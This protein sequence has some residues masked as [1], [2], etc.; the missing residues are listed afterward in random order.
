[1]LHESIWQR[2]ISISVFCNCR[3]FYPPGSTSWKAFSLFHNETYSIPVNILCCFFQMVGLSFWNKTPL[4]RS[5]LYVYVCVSCREWKYKTA[6]VITESGQKSEMIERGRGW[7]HG[8]VDTRTLVNES[9]ALVMNWTDR[10]SF[11]GW[12]DGDG[13][14]SRSWSQYSAHGDEKYFSGVGVFFAQMS[15]TFLFWLIV[16]LKRYITPNKPPALYMVL[17]G[18]AGFTDRHW[19][20][21]RVF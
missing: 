4:W 11:R 12:R 7:R 13:D 3:W 1:M 9:A 5:T 19:I 18:T 21:I 6:K 20:N 2:C 16:T 14:D 15:Y 10:E 17:S 8:R